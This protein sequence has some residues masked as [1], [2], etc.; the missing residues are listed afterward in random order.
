MSNGNGNGAR[1]TIRLPL[2]L[3]E[4]LKWIAKRDRRSLNAFLVVEL[5]RIAK[6]RRE[7][8]DA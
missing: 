6:E 1:I 4:E 5:E 3:R 8:R 2:G 7:R